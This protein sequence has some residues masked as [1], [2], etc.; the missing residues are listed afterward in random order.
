MRVLPTI[1]LVAV[2]ALGAGCDSS[3]PDRRQVGDLVVSFT[4]GRTGQEWAGE[5]RYELPLVLAS[6]QDVETWADGLPADADESEIDPVRAVDLEEHVLIVGGYHSCTETSAIIV[7]EDGGDLT[8]FFEV[9]SDEDIDC[10]WSPYTIDVWAVPLT[11]TGMA[12]P[13][14]VEASRL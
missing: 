5:L 10:A 1:A 9:S 4:E 13:D 3:G 2:V 11:E 8:V 12:P 14:H 6:D 7:E